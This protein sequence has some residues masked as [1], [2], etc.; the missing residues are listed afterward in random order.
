MI[1][2]NTVKILKQMN[3]EP[4][5]AHLLSYHIISFDDRKDLTNKSC[6]D[7]KLYIIEKV[8]N[9]TEE[10]FHNFLK[11]LEE[12]EDDSNHEL[13][14]HLQQYQTNKELPP[15]CQ[16]VTLNTPCGSM[17]DE[18]VFGEM[19][20]QAQSSLK[21]NRS[22]SESRAPSN[23]PLHNGLPNQYKI[24][25]EKPTLSTESLNFQRPSLPMNTASDAQK[26]LELSTDS[27]VD[28]CPQ[29]NII[30]SKNLTLVMEY[31]C[32]KAIES[33]T[34]TNCGQSTF[35]Q[36]KNVRKSIKLPKEVYLT[37]DPKTITST[38]RAADEQI[39]QPYKDLVKILQKL[40]TT[41]HPRI[42]IDLDPILKRI[43]YSPNKIILSDCSIDYLIQAVKKLNQATTYRPCVIL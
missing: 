31:I 38:T 22:K 14:L 27:W 41:S 13:M 24:K 16:S 25:M 26:F 23:Y 9:G 10:T 35:T 28:V 19:S 12:C 40:Q 1:Q 43:H 7:Q 39:K 36:L 3:Y 5:E 42:N 15:L 33:L 20:F 18:L 34:G 4:I 21:R 11:A 17:T 8:V 2:S 6:K 29:T 30:Y 37:A 32:D